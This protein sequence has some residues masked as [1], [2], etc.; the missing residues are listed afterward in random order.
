MP[1]DP[2]GP[3]RL[4]RIVH[5]I[6]GTAHMRMRCAPRF[7]YARAGHDA[8]RSD[9]GET[10]LFLPEKGEAM[11]LVATVPLETEGSDAVAGFEVGAGQ[12]ATF[13]LDC[14]GEDGELPCGL[15]GYGAQCF[16]QTVHFWRDW[17]G[18]SD[19]AGRFDPVV[20]RSALVLKLMTSRDYGSIVA[21]PT[22][23]LPE[24]IGGAR[25]WDYR[26]TWI[27]DAAF[28]VYAFVRVGLV[29][30]A[31]AFMDWIYARMMSGAQDG[32]LQIMYG[33]D[34]RE[35]LPERELDHLAGYAGSQPVR[36]GNAAYD[37]LQLDSYGALL[38]AV[39]LANKHSTKISFDGW[40]AVSRTVDWVCENWRRPDEGIWEFR[41][42][43]REFL[44]SRLMCWVAVDRAVRMSQK[45]SLPGPVD[46]WQK[47]RNEI[48]YSIFDDF[49]SDDRGAFVQYKGSTALDASCLLMPLVKFVSP[50]DPKWLSTLDAVGEELATGEMVRRYDVEHSADVD[51]LEGEE[52]SFT[53]CS[54]WYVE[55]LARAG[56]IDE[57]RLTFE[58]LQGY[59]NHVGLY[60]EELGKAGEHLGNFPQAL[61][62]LS[63]ISA[64]TAI[65][66]AIETGAR[67]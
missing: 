22:F 4:V 54:F 6:R 60:A 25:N 46:K 18:T 23:G 65:D 8:E 42:G 20:R 1:V 35:E 11:R 61:T 5:C 58:K 7:D 41:G 56:R 48:H 17:L 2:D 52:G 24:T 62:H 39:Y 59:A 28:T 44:S 13:L 55:C 38:D 12:S 40:R 63:L 19:Y 53:V 64:A 31:D 21:A 33:I 30:E 10:V 43:R 49:W 45:F 47:V 3:Q 16:E 27:R 51:G 9:D 66:R 67:S 37:Q 57:A 36:I 50:T 34:G 32:S 26:Y 29:S 15:D 14:P